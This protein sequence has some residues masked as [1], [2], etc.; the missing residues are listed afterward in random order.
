[1]NVVIHQ[2][3]QQYHRERHL[4]HWQSDV[5][6][7]ENVMKQMSIR[8]DDRQNRIFAREKELDV[9][10]LIIGE[11]ESDLD[12]REVIVSVREQN[13]GMVG[14]RE[15]M[16]HHRERS[17]QYREIEVDT[18]AQDLQIHEQNIQARESRITNREIEAASIMLREHR[19]IQI[20]RS[21]KRREAMLAYGERRVQGREVRL[22]KQQRAVDKQMKSICSKEDS[23]RPIFVEPSHGHAH[24]FSSNL[25]SK[26]HQDIS[27]VEDGIYINTYKNVTNPKNSTE[28]PEDT[29]VNSCHDSFVSKGSDAYSD[30]DSEGGAKINIPRRRPHA[31]SGMFGSEA[32]IKSNSTGTNK[33][34]AKI[35]AFRRILSVGNGAQ[36]HNTGRLEDGALVSAL[37]TATGQLDYA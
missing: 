3:N 12:A 26:N 18:R 6:R 23:N 31:T 35:S 16:V 5:V 36:V 33:K 30:G 7:R 25:D 9:Q 10:E 14:I 17:L 24:D 34:G 8:L 19:V 15:T 21:F 28:S 13:C 1:M 22:R 27:I 20:E 32:I 37:K 11:R 4:S 2:H 29:L